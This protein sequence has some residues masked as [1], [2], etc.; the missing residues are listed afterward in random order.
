[1]IGEQTVDVDRA[2][3]FL[4]E[5]LEVDRAAISE[6]FLAHRVS[7]N[8]AM[9]KH[10]TVQVGVVRDGWDLGVLGLINGLFGVDERQWGFIAM[11][12]R[13]GGRGELVKFERTQSRREKIEEPE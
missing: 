6:L 13:D 12:F 1:M 5:L 4:N 9:A 3:A 10:E 8:E 2:I 7:C 11:Q